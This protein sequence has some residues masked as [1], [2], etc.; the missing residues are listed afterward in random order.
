MA[1]LQTDSPPRN[2]QFKSQNR[3]LNSDLSPR[4]K[5]NFSASG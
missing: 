1:F 3:E 5:V 4:F 2:D